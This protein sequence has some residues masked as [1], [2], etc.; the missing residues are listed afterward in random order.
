MPPR[1]LSLALGFPRPPR[2]AS[3][4]NS[5]SPLPHPPVALRRSGRPRRDPPSPSPGTRSPPP[6]HL[7][8]Q[9]VQLLHVAAHGLGHGVLRAVQATHGVRRA[10]QV[11]QLP[12][13][14]RLPPWSR[15]PGRASAA[16]LSPRAASRR[17]C[18]C[19]RCRAPLG[20]VPRAPSPSRG[21]ARTPRWG[22]GAQDTR[23]RCSLSRALSSTTVKPAGRPRGTELGLPQPA[24]L[25]VK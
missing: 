7:R 17:R 19:R 25:S 21:R 16:A 12:R 11:P 13:L 8:A 2:L 23:Y 24:S 9:L 6:A 1:R 14:P 22:G 18:R 15:G 4:P 10:P 5:P 20:R 3:D